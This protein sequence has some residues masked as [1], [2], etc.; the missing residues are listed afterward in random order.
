MKSIFVAGVFALAAIALAPRAKADG[1]WYPPDSSCYKCIIS[2]INFGPFPKIGA[3]CREVTQDGEWGSGT[4]C[5]QENVYTSPGY[6]YQDCVFTGGEC[7]VVIFQT[8]NAVQ[9][10]TPSRT[11]GTARENVAYVF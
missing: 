1:I 6:Y 5:W 3:M 9:P 7:M 4:G 8:P 11:V 2:R 10:A